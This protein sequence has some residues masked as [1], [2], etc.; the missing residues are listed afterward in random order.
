[1]HY[2]QLKLR[3][4]ESEVSASQQFPEQPR[5]LQEQELQRRS[6]QVVPAA[7][8][9]HETDFS[10]PRYDAQLHEFPGQFS[11]GMD[12]ASNVTRYALCL[13]YEAN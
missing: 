10:T 12:T 13:K 7:G 1:M 3:R 6:A 8:G 5:Y 4:Q 11:Q 9:Y 2:R